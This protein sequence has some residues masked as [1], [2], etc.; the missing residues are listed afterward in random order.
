MSTAVLFVLFTLAEMSFI[1]HRESISASL[2][3]LFCFF[4]TFSDEA[5]A[6]VVA[7]QMRGARSGAALT[8]CQDAQEQGQQGTVELHV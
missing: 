1:W 5:G 7:E 4:L 2:L 6:I 8:N 3:A